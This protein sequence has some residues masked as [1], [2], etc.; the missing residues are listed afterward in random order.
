M[1][2]APT[3]RA[4]YEYNP[5]CDCEVCA[6]GGVARDGPSTGHSFCY[7]QP[8]VP[9]RPLRETMAAAGNDEA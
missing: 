9:P 4:E 8:H 2:P 3:G 6:N 7:G 1:Q 5:A